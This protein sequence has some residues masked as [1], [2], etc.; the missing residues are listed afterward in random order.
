MFNELEELNKL[1]SIEEMSNFVKNN[2]DNLEKLN[3]NQRQQ[4][5]D[6]LVDKSMH[7]I[8]TKCLNTEFAK[9]VNVGLDIGLKI[10][11]PDYIDDK[12]IEIKNNI[13]NNG[14]KEGLEKSFNDSIEVGKSALN[15]LTN[16]FESISDAKSAI[17]AGGAIDKI[18]DLIDDGV[19]VLKENKKIDS[20]TAKTIKNEKNNIIKNIEKN[21]DKS[22]EEQISNFEKLEKYISNWKEAYNSQDFNLMQ[23]EYKKMQKLMENLMPLENTI[24]EFRTIENLQTLI[25]NNGKNFDLTPEAL[26]LANKLIK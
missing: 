19:E 26:E 24:N 22:F 12:V 16:N 18:S 1:N 25:K 5:V 15:I 10:I 6:T 21:L 4:I 23:K 14:F 11:L 8:Q 7:E 9:A 17:K 13:M 3:L 2:K 20:K